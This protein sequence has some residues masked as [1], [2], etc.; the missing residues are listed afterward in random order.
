MNSLVLAALCRLAVLVV[1]SAAARL[2]STALVL[3]F[4]RCPKLLM[5]NTRAMGVQGVVRNAAIASKVFC[6]PCDVRKCVCHVA[7]SLYR[8]A[9]AAG[10]AGAAAP[11][12]AF[13]AAAGIFAPLRRTFRVFRAGY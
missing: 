6:I 10:A 7:I 9:F 13:A 12:V 4:V 1:L 2:A 5:Q 3:H 8:S 11:A